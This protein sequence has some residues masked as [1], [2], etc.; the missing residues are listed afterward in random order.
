MRSQK[1][2]PFRRRVRYSKPMP[3]SS[4]GWLWNIWKMP[5]LVSLLLAAIMTLM[6]DEHAPQ[7]LGSTEWVDVL[8]VYDGDTLTVFI[9]TDAGSSRKQRVRL[10]GIDTAELGGARC[11]AERNLAVQQRDYLRSLVGDKV[12]LSIFGTD[13]YG[14]LLADVYNEADENVGDRMIAEAGARHYDGGRRSGWC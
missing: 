12:Q 6:Q 4:R 14:R 7:I 8:H 5:L 13:R 10:V 3:R 1:V 9:S 2:V 11:N